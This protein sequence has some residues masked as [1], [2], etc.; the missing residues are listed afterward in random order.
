ML[1]SRCSRGS[2]SVENGERGSSLSPLQTRYDASVYQK[3]HIRVYSSPMLERTTLITVES[4]TPVFMDIPTHPCPDMYM[5]RIVLS[6][7]LTEMSAGLI[8]PLKSS[9]FHDLVLQ[10]GHLRGTCVVLE[11]H[12]CPHTTQLLTIGSPCQ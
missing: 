10:D 12:S 5:S 7:P 2:E 11:N 9:D 3:V 6:V 8:L 1:S 4:A